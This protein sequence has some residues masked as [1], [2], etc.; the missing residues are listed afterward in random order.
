MPY[1]IIKA[2]VIQ[3]SA[4]N[5]HDVGDIGVGTVRYNEAT[6]IIEIYANDQWQPYDADK[7]YGLITSSPTSFADYGALS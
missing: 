7:D 1:G 2:D 6:G 5:S 3:D 4:G